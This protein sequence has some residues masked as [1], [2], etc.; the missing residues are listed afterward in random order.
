MSDVFLSNMPV[1]TWIHVL[2]MEIVDAN[3]SIRTRLDVV[4]VL[5]SEAKVIGCFAHAV[6]ERTILEGQP[7][8]LDTRVFFQIGCW[9]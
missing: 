6:S 2:R 5:V 3:I 1:E 9:E 4:L 8:S 7:T